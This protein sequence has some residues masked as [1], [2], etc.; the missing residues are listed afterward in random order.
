MVQR[1][2]NYAIVDEVD[3]ILVDE[4][5]T[6]LIISGPLDDRSEL[7]NTI[8]TFIP[9]L[10]EDDYEVD[11]KQRTATFTEAGNEKLEKLLARRR[12]A[13][14]RLALRR[15]ERHRRP[16]R[17]PG[18][19]RPPP[20]PAR[21]GL[22]RQE[23]RGRH[24]RRVHRPHDARPALFGRPAPGARGQ[25]A[26]ADPAGE[27]D[28]RLDHLPELLPHVRQARRHDRH[29]VDRGGGVRRHL[30]P[31]RRRDPD[32]HADGPHRRRRRGL[33]DGGREIQ[34]DHHADQG[35]PRAR[36]ADPGRHHL[37]REVRNPRRDAAPRR[38]CRIRC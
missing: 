33:P 32:Q 37:D 8:D 2:H 31:R 20:V 19:A 14:G 21:Q 27:P 16:P 1:G 13:Q 5:R 17:Q 34:G 24:H 7:Y 26:P 29:G 18:A 3:S 36:P 23:R 15:R 12:P 28:A 10:T 25:G 35:L 11:E 6:P 38:R 22:H 4:A 30:R 9:Q